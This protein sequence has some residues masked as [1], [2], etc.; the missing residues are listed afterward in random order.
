MKV[1]FGTVVYKESYG[2]CR[3]YLESV[4]NQDYIQF[5]VVILN[6][7]LVE[8]ELDYLKSNLNKRTIVIEGYTNSSPSM[9]RMQLIKT[10]K[11][12]DY[13]LMVMGDFDDTFS[14]NRVSEIVLEY[15]QSTTFY[16]NDICL[17]GNCEK[18]FENLP[19]ETFEV[20]TI[21]EQNYLG[22]SNTALN[23]TSINFG[24]I[25]EIENCSVPIF[26]WFFY[27]VLLENNHKGKKVN[28]CLTYYRIHGNNCAGES[29]NSVEYL[30]KE[31]NVKIEHY[32]N[33]VNFYSSYA[34]LLEFYKVLKL[35]IN[36]D[37]FNVLKHSSKGNCYWWGKLNSNKMKTGD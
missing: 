21:L 11:L 2:F 30:K 25:D 19:Q 5:D 17:M 7:N 14:I 29:E 15:N 31:I 34:R 3:D 32:T 8:E 22:L 6:D 16:Y 18:F 35:K 36:T 37:A 24:L 10:A 26:D 4:N 28:N 13:D 20:A 23:L 33:L 1:C 27:T 9:L 12:M